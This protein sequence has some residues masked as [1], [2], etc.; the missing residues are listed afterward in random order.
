MQYGQ[1]ERGGGYNFH[2]FTSVSRE[3]VTAAYP[4]FNVILGHSTYELG[5]EIANQIPQINKVFYAFSIHYEQY[6]RTPYEELENNADRYVSLCNTLADEKSVD[7][8][9][10]YLNTRLMG[11]VSHI[12]HVYDKQMSFYHNDVFQMS[13]HEVFLDIGAYNGD[14]IKLFLAETDGHYDK[15]IALEPDGESFLALNE[16]IAEER[17]RNV[18]VSKSGAWD[19]R[20]ELQFKTGNEQISSVDIGSAILN[21]SDVI[22][23]HADRLD[24][25]FETEDITFIKINYYQGIVEAI[26]GCEGILMSKH[27]KLAMDVGFDVY[28]VLEL[29]EYIASLNLGYKLYLRFNRAMTSTFTLYAMV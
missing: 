14:T 11:D 3:A 8:L 25:L 15:I 23:I 10:A 4:R 22:T 24:Y 26:K 19:K 29:A 12:F 21:A 18:V 5:L 2:G 16:Y 17:L 28:K 6:D 27:P 13:D 1:M 9:M 7:N 20:E